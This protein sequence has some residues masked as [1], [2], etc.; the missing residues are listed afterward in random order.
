MLRS[1]VAAARQGWELDGLGEAR[2]AG[3][4]VRLQG[5]AAPELD[6]PGGQS[7]KNAMIALVKDKRVSCEL[8]GITSHDRVGGTC[9]VADKDVAARLVPG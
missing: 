4:K 3:Q 2:V 1:C 6:G 5:L 7:A 9:Y 8:D